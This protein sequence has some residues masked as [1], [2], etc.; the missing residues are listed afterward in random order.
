MNKIKLTKQNLKDYPYLYEV[1]QQ[2]KKK[3]QQYKDNAP[4][5]T[6]GKV[7]GSNPVFPFELRSFTVSGPDFADRK[8]WELKVRYL[9]VKLSAEIN[10]YNQITL[11]IDT[12]IA[13]IDDV[14]DKLIMELLIKQGKTQEE[15]ARMYNLDQC[16]ISR[17]INK[18]INNKIA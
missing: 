2:D 14:R 10:L 12:M 13:N 8:D 15:V 11:E 18:Y 9:E 16:N 6:H 7:V 5:A 3:L 17:R 1:I 4:V